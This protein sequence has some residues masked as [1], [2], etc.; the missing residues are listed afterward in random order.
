MNTH[1][2]VSLIVMNNKRREKLSHLQEFY[3]VEMVQSFSF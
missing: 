1:N 2:L 3:K